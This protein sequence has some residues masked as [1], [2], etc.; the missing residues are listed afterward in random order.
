[1]NPEPPQASQQSRSA[2]LTVVLGYAAF[3]AL[4]ILVSDQVVAWLLNDSALIVIASTL[5]GWVF[6]A[7]TSLLL[8]QLLRRRPGFARAALDTQANTP[9]PTSW[10]SLHLPLALAAVAIVA[11]TA[12]AITH[13]LNRHKEKE[14]ARLQTI[15][16]LKTRQI[17]DWLKERQGD[18]RFLQSSHALAETYHHWRERGDSTSRNQLFARLEQFRASKAYQS[19]LLLDEQGEP[20]WDSVDGIFTT[21]PKLRAAARQ[22][23]AAKQAGQ[24][25][26]Y[27][28]AGGHLYLDFAATLSA[29]DGRS[30]P[31]V[32]L[33]SDPAAY[34]FPLLQTWPVPSA[35]AE[36]LLFR[37]DGEQVLF[38]NDLRHRP[39]S[40]AKLHVPVAT[41][42]LLAAQVL[43]GEVEQDSLIEGVDYRAVPVLG[44]ARAV[45]GTD[46]FLVAKLD[47]AEL[48]ED[49]WNDSL[50]IALTGLLALF[51]TA[52]GAVVLRQHQTMAESQRASTV[53]T[54]K[55]R[56]LQLL[57]AFAKG[58]DDAIFVKDAEGRY[59]LFNRAAGEM[60]G[61][62]AQEVLGRDD[63]SIFPPEDAA[64]LM[65]ID[66]RVRAENRVLTGEESLTTSKG[67]RVLL[68]TKGPLHDA[69]GKVIG[70]FG[71][72][73]DITE[74]KRMELDLQ[75]SAA[76]LKETLSRTQLLIDSAL[77]AVVCIDQDG[78]VVTWN[79]HAESLFGY[80]AEQVVGRD[81]AE[82][83][84]PP[85]YREQHR[86]GMARF[87]A[88]GKQKVIGKRLELLGMRADGTEF[89]MEL[90]IG[91]LREDGKYLFS[92]YI[93]DITERKACR[94][95]AAQ[96]LAG[97][98]T[99]PG[100]HRHH[101]R[102]RPNRIRRTKPS[103][104]PPATAARK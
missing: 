19:V 29:Q 98:G 85:V 81:M 77:D 23:V 10:R 45:P 100:K 2:I 82:L 24:L 42:K 94:G 43:R 102:R 31:V 22:A 48:F 38:L 51:M 59:L 47:R 32:I 86:Q 12:G 8:Y 101:Q 36:T 50:W 79:S 97:R 83:I 88:T 54:E 62:T 7:I 61:K 64:M 69:E 35:S 96:A 25:P 14:A 57:D 73:R 70:V 4:W 89:P 39:D 34:L 20:L 9:A 17:A 44:V 87:M 49:A 18:A 60:V 67:L 84:V 40:A 15:A 65:A 11:L 63:T 66:S 30:G 56:A 72:S 1:M 41:Q 55:L 53:Q 80:P 3:G 5:K 6:I 68:A 104:G 46:W 91:S 21:D 74:R 52:V 26:P 76:S 27:R 28:D 16:D 95:T 33:R 58:S 90:T 92:A 78:R 71:I 103:S 75:A 13:D 37:R 93:H 99:K